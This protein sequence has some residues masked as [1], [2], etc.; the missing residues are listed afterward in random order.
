MIGETYALL[1]LRMSD[2]TRMF[3][4]QD[5]LEFATSSAAAKVIPH[6]F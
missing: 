6:M 2:C 4:L 3:A 1:N 5:F